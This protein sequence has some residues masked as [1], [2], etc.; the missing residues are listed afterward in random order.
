[1]AV[2]SQCD[3]M[4]GL[5]SIVTLLLI[6]LAAAAC[7]QS[8]G[9][10]SVGGKTDLP[11]CGW[12]VCDAPRIE[13]D[14][15]LITPFGT[16]GADLSEHELSRVRLEPD[17]DMSALQLQQILVGM[18]HSVQLDRAAENLEEAFEGVDENEVDLIHLQIELDFETVEADWLRFYSGDTQV[19]ILFQHDKT[20]IIGEVSDGEVLG[21]MADNGKPEEP[22]C[23]YELQRPFGGSS[24]D[25]RDSVLSR[26]EYKASDAAGLSVLQRQQILR[27]GEL[28][29]DS[30]SIAET[31][32]Y[33]DEGEITFIE[34]LHEEDGLRTD[35]LW[36]SLAAGD[37]EIG[38][39]FKPG[40]TE[41]IA[42]VSDGAVLACLE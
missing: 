11:D 9:G 35:A 20:E 28:V 34:L 25:L 5:R 3:S 2:A 8:A 38:L 40:T 29:M 23:S 1:M 39:L 26:V 19:G 6:P 36:I 37:T 7:Q 24:A 27:T 42:E 18:G 13:C 16:T 4:S 41:V 17:S 15:D 12:D 21:C 31:F 14:Y 32:A 30:L 22:T 33:A 10:P